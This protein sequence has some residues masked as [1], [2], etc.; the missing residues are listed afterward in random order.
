MNIVEFAENY[1]KL[2][3]PEYQKKILWGFHNCGPGSKFIFVPT[4]SGKTLIIKTNAEY[5]KRRDC[6]ER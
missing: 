1:L 2:K 5:E 3:L 6:N 4:R